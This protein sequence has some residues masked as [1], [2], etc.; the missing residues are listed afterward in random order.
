MRKALLTPFVIAGLLLLPSC[1]SAEAKACV[2]A[3]KA[4]SEFEAET[5]KAYEQR[6][7]SIKASDWN[8]SKEYLTLAN[9]Y[10]FWTQKV[11][12]NNPS[13]FT[14]AQVVI[15]QSFVGSN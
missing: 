3:E 12:V 13:C 11:I 8:S 10:E 4:Y 5:K 1:S 9:K 15:A 2:S 14:A 6:E 7:I